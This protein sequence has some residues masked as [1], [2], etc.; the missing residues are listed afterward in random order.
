M[1]KTCGWRGEDADT[2]GWLNSAVFFIP[3]RRITACEGW[4]TQAAKEYTRS[5]PRRENPYSRNATAT[6]V[7]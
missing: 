6:Y 1:Y 3:A 2:F 7:A 4:F 5:N